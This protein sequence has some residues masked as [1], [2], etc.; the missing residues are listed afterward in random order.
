MKIKLVVAA[1][2][3]LQVGLVSSQGSDVNMR[4]LKPAFNMSLCVDNELTSQPLAPRISKFKRPTDAEG[5]IWNSVLDACFKTLINEE[6][7]GMVY[8]HFKGK[9]PEMIAY[10]DGLLY[11]ARATVFLAVEKEWKKLGK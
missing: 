9:T 4:L 7:E 1:F 3:L 10:R 11:A 2:L 6:T 8:Q 5:A